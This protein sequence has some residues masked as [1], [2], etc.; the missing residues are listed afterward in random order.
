MRGINGA[1][2]AATPA[3]GILAQGQSMGYPRTSGNIRP[4]CNEGGSPE[5]GE[6]SVHAQS[7]ASHSWEYVTLM[8]FPARY[9]RGG[10]SEIRREGMSQVLGWVYLGRSQRGPGKTVASFSQVCAGRI[11]RIGDS[12]A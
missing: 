7:G 5:T 8:S 4:C 2:V 3:R 9:W 1:G 10:S 11:P 6:A 12:S